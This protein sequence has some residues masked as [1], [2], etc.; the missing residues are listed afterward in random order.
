MNIT[1]NLGTYPISVNPL[2][3]WSMSWV[4]HLLLNPSGLTMNCI[5]TLTHIQGRTCIYYPL[6]GIL[7][8]FGCTSAGILRWDWRR[9]HMHI[10]PH[11][12]I[13]TPL[14]GS[15]GSGRI[16]F[17]DYQWTGLKICLLHQKIVTHHHPPP[18]RADPWKNRSGVP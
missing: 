14:F 9:G 1:R 2:T 4:L 6:V 17:L 12:Y 11:L 3:P 16:Q 15:K 10:Y 18:Q 7:P 8:Q 5:L 13:I